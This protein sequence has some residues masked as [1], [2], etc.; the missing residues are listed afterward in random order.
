[1]AARAAP[2][3]LSRTRLEAAHWLYSSGSKLRD[4]GAHS[5]M[6]SYRSPGLVRRTRWHTWSRALENV[7]VRCRHRH[8]AFQWH[9]RGAGQ[10]SISGSAN[11]RPPGIVSRVRCQPPRGCR[12]VV[13]AIR[14]QIAAVSEQLQHMANSTWH[15]ICQVPSLACWRVTGHSTSDQQLNAYNL[16]TPALTD[17]PPD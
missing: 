5:T 1:M 14:W 11:R 17:S 13:S 7:E 9:I 12:C 10:R 15:G 6:S 4:F 16:L 8:N 2:A 3:L